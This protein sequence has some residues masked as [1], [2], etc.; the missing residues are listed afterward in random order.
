[1]RILAITLLVL[2]A[3]TI[4]Y[5]VVRLPRTAMSRRTKTILVLVVTVAVLV[6]VFRS[7][8]KRSLPG[9]IVRFAAGQGGAVQT[10]ED[11]ADDVR[12]KS[13]LSGL[14]QW[15][16]QVLTRCRSGTLAT[17]GAASYWSVGTVRLAASE[18]PDFITRA[19]SE[20]PE[21]SVRISQTGQPECVAICWYLHGLAVGSPEYILSFQPWCM[22]QVKPGIYAYHLYK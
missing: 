16:A 11:L 3:V 12:Q 5:A 6:F 22:N 7:G 4:T 9:R 14:Q 20:Q 18:I 17:N 15:S 1:M 8:F 13:G 2:G 21:V 10:T 19:W